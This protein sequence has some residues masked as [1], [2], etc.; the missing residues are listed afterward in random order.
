MDIL[1]RRLD[2]VLLPKMWEYRVF[3]R[4]NFLR[5]SAAV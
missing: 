2:L 1:V 4:L 5:R 3:R